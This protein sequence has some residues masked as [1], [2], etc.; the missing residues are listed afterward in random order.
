MEAVPPDIAKKLLSR[1]FAN[2]VARVQK[3]GKLTLAHVSPD[4]ATLLRTMRLDKHFSIQ[5]A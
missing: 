3:G 5:P 2:L 1:D 4:L